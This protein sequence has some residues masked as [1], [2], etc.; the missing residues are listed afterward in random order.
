M[1]KRAEKVK[2][3]DV[4]NHPEG[5]EVMGKTKEG[6]VFVGKIEKIVRYDNGIPE[7][8]SVE[9][10]VHDGKSNIPFSQI[11]TLDKMKIFDEDIYNSAVEMM[12]RYM[13]FTECADY[14][15][16]KSEEIIS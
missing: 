14:F 9:G 16:N 7:F 13:I 8:V 11:T 12:R 1:I 6:S 4:L 5:L 3:T 10:A 15:K 2:S